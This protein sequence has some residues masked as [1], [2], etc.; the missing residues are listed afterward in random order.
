MEKDPFV[1]DYILKWWFSIANFRGL[2]EGN[3]F[4]T[5]WGKEMA[6]TTGGAAGEH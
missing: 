3:R 2:P 6:E 1:E 5:V 4:T